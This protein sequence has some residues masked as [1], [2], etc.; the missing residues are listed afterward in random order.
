M[1]SWDCAAFYDGD[2]SRWYRCRELVTADMV[3]E[4][5]SIHAKKFHEVMSRRARR[6]WFQGRGS[7]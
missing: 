4:G 5:R 6:A 2:Y 7:V 1:P 3:A